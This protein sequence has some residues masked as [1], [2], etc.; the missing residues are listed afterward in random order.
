MINLG[1]TGLIVQYIQNFLKDNYNPNI[2]LSDEYDKETHATLIEYLKLPEIIDS[3]SMKDLILQNFT[4]REEQPPNL[5]INGGGVWNFDFDIT[6]DTIRFFNRPISQCFDGAL[7]FINEYTDEIDELCRQHGWHLTHYSKFKYDKNTQASSSIEFVLTKDSRKQLL[8]SKDIINMI[9]LSTNEYLLGKC[10]LDENNAYHGVMQNSN[11]YKISYIPVKPGDK[12]TVS[13]GYKYPC[14]I[15]IGY[16]ESTLQEL[17]INE[18]VTVYNLVSHLSKSTYGELNPGDYVIY[19]IPKD[20]DAKYLLIQMPYKNNLISPTTKKI[21]VQVGDINQDGIIDFDENNPES[22]YMILK[23][24]VDAKSEGKDSPFT[25]SGINLIAANINRD[26]DIDGK[27][28]V[29]EIDLKQFEAAI[30]AYNKLGKSIDFGEAVYEKEIDLSESDYD[31]LLVMYGDIEENNKNNELNIPIKDYQNT[32]WLIHDCFL[33]YILG[34]AIHTYS[35]ARDV[36]WLQKQIVII[37]PRYEGLRWGHYDSPES[38]ISDDYFKWNETKSKYEYYINGLYTGYILSSNDIFNSDIRRESNLT[39]MDIRIM[40]GKIMTNDKWTGKLVLKD[41]TITKELSQYSLREI[42]KQFQLSTNNFY[43]E[44]SKEQI[45]FING[46]VDPLTEK[47]LKQ[48]IQ[49]F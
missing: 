23:R 1:D 30:E 5:L 35:D 43:K 17:K 31:R 24:Y 33:P 20:S 40:N 46:F 7:R 28:I 6:L 11:K 18:Y 9:N 25:L 32:P 2:H 14:E 12:F 13:H 27:P 41:G 42:V 19:E 48:A 4:F 22:D 49:E 3:Y 8:P 34:S 36:E 21:N 16:T 47:R 10:F 15:A 26:M 29:D 38:F 37:Q 44:Q 45:K 39:L